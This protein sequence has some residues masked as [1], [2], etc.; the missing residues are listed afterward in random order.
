MAKRNGARP[1]SIYALPFAVPLLNFPFKPKACLVK[2]I[3]YINCYKGSPDVLQ[4]VYYALF[5]TMDYGCALISYYNLINKHNT[6][7]LSTTN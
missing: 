5:Y 4:S 3:Y 6:I 2:I 7:V 1:F